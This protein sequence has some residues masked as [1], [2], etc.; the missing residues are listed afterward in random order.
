MTRRRQCHGQLRFHCNGWSQ[1]QTPGGPITVTECDKTCHCVDHAD[2]ASKQDFELPDS[3]SSLSKVQT[4]SHS[5]HCHSGRR[6]CLGGSGGGDRQSCPAGCR[7][8]RGSG[9][10]GATKKAGGGSV[11]TPACRPA[12][13]SPLQC[14]DLGLASHASAGTA[15]SPESSPPPSPRPLSPVPLP[16]PPPTAGA[17]SAV[18]AA[19]RAGDL[20]RSGVQRSMAS[21]GGCAAA[22]TLTSVAAAA[23]SCSAR[24][25]GR[26]SVRA[27]PPRPPN[28]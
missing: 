28:R 7:T 24:F 15:S 20:L 11:S 14:G 1:H 4:G 26:R 9:G 23:E 10:A 17:G 6:S 5:G 8:L 2:P 18:V 13:E 16:T 21:G 25:R 27:V 22:S 19:S 3:F 12:G